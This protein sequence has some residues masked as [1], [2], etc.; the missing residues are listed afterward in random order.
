MLNIFKPIP[1]KKVMLMPGNNQG[2]AICGVWMGHDLNFI[3]C[4]S[5]V[6]IEE[7]LF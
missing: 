2:L 7:V 3:M 6:F 4:E 1:I 5:N